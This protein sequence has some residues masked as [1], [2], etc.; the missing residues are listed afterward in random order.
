MSMPRVCQVLLGLQMRDSLLEGLEVLF[1]LLDE[2][3]YSGMCLTMLLLGR[4]G[5]S[6]LLEFGVVQAKTHE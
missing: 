3:A 4:K 6:L 1:F 2:A 5:V